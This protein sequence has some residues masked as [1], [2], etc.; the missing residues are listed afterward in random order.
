MGANTG[1]RGP[2]AART[3]ETSDTQPFDWGS[4]A[5]LSIEILVHNG[6]VFEEPEYYEPERPAQI[7]TELRDLT[8]ARRVDVSHIDPELGAGT[9]GLAFL[10]QFL[11]TGAAVITWAVAVKAISPRIRR[12]IA[13]L[14][15]LSGAVP[16]SRTVSFCG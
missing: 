6:E 2:G 16:L 10:F 1:P 12:A 3:S 5:G 7:A 8:Q 13:H 14:R 15:N 4:E 11:Q 9:N